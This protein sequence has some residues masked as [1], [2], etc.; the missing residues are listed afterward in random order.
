[1]KSEYFDTNVSVGGRGN[2]PFFGFRRAAINNTHV[3][4]TKSFSMFQREQFLQVRMEARNA[5]NRAWFGR[6]GD[7][8]P[9]E[10][11]GKIIDTQNKGRV[12]QLMIRL[13][14]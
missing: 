8:F 6:P 11:F 4:L 5:L 10:V 3:V 2:S 9:T 12:L 1:M 13:N 7:I 14:F